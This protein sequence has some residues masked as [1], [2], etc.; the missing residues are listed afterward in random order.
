MQNELLITQPEPQPTTKRDEIISQLVSKSK[1]LSYSTLKKFTTPVSFLNALENPLKPNE[2]M[3]FGSLCDTLILSPHELEVKF[4]VVAKV[5][6]TDLQVSFADGLI[7]IGKTTKLTPEV[8]EAEFKNHYSRGDAGKTY[9]EL[10]A[11]VTAS[12]SG[13][14]LITP[15]LLA[16]AQEISDNVLSSPE[17][18]PWLS[19]ITDVQKRIDWTENGWN[20]I[21]F[22]DAQLGQNIGELKYTKEATPEK[23]ERE[24]ANH[25]YYLQAAMYCYAAEKTGLTVSPRHYSL[26]Y[27]KK[28]NIAV[29]EMDQSY[30]N[31]GFREYKYLIQQLEKCIDLSAWSESYGFFKPKYTVSK[32]KWAKAILLEGELEPY[33]I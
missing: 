10:S 21:A 8:I 2:G 23:F 22:L 9:E 24:I 29:I 16:Q 11:Y 26:I 14:K 27:D 1:R 4:Q 25:K 30:I 17:A 28:K 5:P 3:N 13:K 12:I 33:D 19:E 15:A 18:A 6:T 32:P 7:Q 20:L 31:Y